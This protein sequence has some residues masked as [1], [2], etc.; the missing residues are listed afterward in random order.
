MKRAIPAALILAILVVLAAAPAAHAGF[1]DKWTKKEAA[2]T[3]A[4]PRYD[5]YPTMTYHTGVLGHGV[6][7]SWTLDDADL[8]VRADCRISSDFGGK[9]ELTAGKEALVTGVKFG[10]TIIAY[11]VRLVKPDYMNAGAVKS[12]E[13]VPSEVDPTVGHGQGPQ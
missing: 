2:Q 12:S 9:A 5:L 7:A 10:S 11:S 13:V 4:A 1:L 8:L 6:A 3:K